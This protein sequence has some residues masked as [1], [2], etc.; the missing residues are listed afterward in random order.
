MQLRCLHATGATFAVRDHD[1]DSDGHGPTIDVADSIVALV[2]V[3]R[4]D[5]DRSGVADAA[6]G[7][8]S[9]MAE[10][11]GEQTVV[12]VPFADLTDT[13]ARQ[14]SVSATLDALA[15]RLGADVHR[16][17]V[18]NHVA[19]DLEARGHPHASQAFEVSPPDRTDGEW[20]RFDDGDLA[21][22]DAHRLLADGRLVD[23][24]ADDR[25]WPDTGPPL[26]DGDTLLPLGT[27]LRDSLV[28]LVTDRF[29]SSGALPADSNSGPLD[30]REFVSDP[31]ALPLALY[32][33][34]L[35]LAAA[36][37]PA[38]ALD[39]FS[40]HLDLLVDLL[41]DLELDVEP[42]CRLDPRF[43]EDNRERIADLTERFDRS[44]LV[45]RRSDPDQPL[46]LELL[47]C[48][49][50]RRLLESAVWLEESEETPV[51]R[52]RLGDSTRPVAA[53]ARRAADR[54]IPHLPA[55]L[56]P[57]QLRLLP[58]TDDDIERCVA[59]A[60]DLTAVRVDIDDRDLPVSQRLDDASQ[61]WIPYDAVVGEGDE[62]R[63]GVTIRSEGR[64]RGVTTD[65]FTQCIDCETAGF[66]DRPRPLP[67]RYTE[68]PD[69]FRSQ[70]NGE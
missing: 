54:D 44:P 32:T 33:D 42:V 36:V 11:L 20:L 9:D 60:E 38:T 65:S 16:V 40:R 28:D 2:A 15:D 8:V 64:E 43:F 50:G 37:R 61:Q 25:L 35:E 55:W 19:V 10:Q 53:I 41:A 23:R 57:T 18:G 3:E 22:A 4:R 63:F 30:P 7:H 39:T 14:R 29:R 67:L 56:S 5:D 68:C 70:S 26:A 47:V 49:E 1:P 59:I 21:P 69:L 52:T 66:P 17:P 48:A 58:L 51:V 34:T 13:P 12:L 6:A 62:E 27:S 46:Q 24:L 31:S 45:E